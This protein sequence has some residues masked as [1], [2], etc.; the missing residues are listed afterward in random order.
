MGSYDYAGCLSVPRIMRLRGDRLVQEPAPE[1]AN[2]RRDG[3]MC[4]RHVTVQ[5]EAS[6]PLRGCY[7][8]LALDIT[9]QLERCAWAASPVSELPEACMC[10]VVL[11]KH[12]LH[13]RS[14]LATSA[15]AAEIA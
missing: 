9:L 1:V 8:S 10:E 2:L 14:A 11:D 3:A 7:G 4:M 12:Q 13:I 6:T 15:L 5:P